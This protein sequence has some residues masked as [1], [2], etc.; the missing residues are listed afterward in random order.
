MRLVYEE[1]PSAKLFVGYALRPPLRARVPDAPAHRPICS[2]LWP[3]QQRRLYHQVTLQD[4][5][6]LASFC[7]S[8]RAQ[9]SVR[10][11]VTQL[12]LRMDD[13]CNLREPS[14]ALRDSYESGPD[15]DVD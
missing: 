9:P 8:V 10:T 12:S 3:I 14:G 15:A 11:F 7:S 13:A 5:T 4:Y 2:R 6:S 1:D